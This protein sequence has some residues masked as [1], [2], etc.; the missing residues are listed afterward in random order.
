MAAMIIWIVIVALGVALIV[1]TS[2]IGAVGLNALVAAMISLVI[3][4][5]AVRENQAAAGGGA[6][7]YQLSA[8]NARYMGLVW[9]WGA[10]SLVL[11]YNAIL[12]WPE[13]WH[14]VIAFAAAAALCLVFANL[15]EAA[16]KGD[17]PGE[18]VLKLSRILAV[19]QLVGALVAVAGLAIDGK[20]AFLGMPSLINGRDWHGDP[21]WVG[22]HVFF[23]GALALAAISAVALGSYNRALADKSPAPAASAVRRRV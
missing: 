2:A 6:G 7:A 11:V 10:V 8:T 23:F 4:I 21:S 9:A 17:V 15:L 19:I 5:L 1:I 3:A 13:W 12:K 22:S 16:A 18:R 14:F 20:L